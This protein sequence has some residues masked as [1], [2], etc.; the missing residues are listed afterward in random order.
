MRI[1][2]GVRQD[3]VCAACSHAWYYEQED[4]RAKLGHAWYMR[5]AGGRRV[6]CEATRGTSARQGGRSVRCEATRGTYA[7]QGAGAC[8]LRPR[9]AHAPG[10][11]RSVRPEATRGTCARYGGG[12]GGGGGGSAKAHMMGLKWQRD[13]LSHVHPA[14]THE[15]HGVLHRLDQV[16]VRHDNELQFLA[17][18]LPELEQGQVEARRD[19]PSVH[20]RLCHAWAAGSTRGLILGH[21]WGCELG[22]PRVGHRCHVRA[23][24]ATRGMKVQG[25]MRGIQMPC[26]TCG[27]EVPPPAAHPAPC[28]P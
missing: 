27:M 22:R 14:R 23:T 21:A 6:R 19:A 17:D 25:A 5:P 13:V 8:G 1:R 3:A 4:E 7:R 20:C 26:T 16:V 28:S 24:G 15:L 11:G 9:V 12:G 18:Q 2:V 10:R